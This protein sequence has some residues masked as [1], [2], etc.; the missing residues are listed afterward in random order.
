MVAFKDQVQNICFCRGELILAEVRGASVENT[1]FVRVVSKTQ[2]GG[3]V[4]RGGAFYLGQF[5]LRP[6]S[7]SS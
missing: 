2:G 5:R 7:F 6:S 3:R 1:Q 4:E